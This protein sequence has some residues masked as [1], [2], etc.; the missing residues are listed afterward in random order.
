MM[1]EEDN[2]KEEIDKE[3]EK[4]EVNEEEIKE[5]REGDEKKEVN[6][7]EGKEEKEETN[8]R[9][10]GEVVKEDEKQGE[11]S[12][13]DEKKEEDNEKEEIDKVEEKD[14]T[15]E[16]KTTEPN[17]IDKEQDKGEAKQLKKIFLVLGFLALIFVGVF[18]F[19]NSSRNFTYD[20]IDFETVKAG[21]L[22]LYKT[23]LPVDSDDHKITGD[24]VSVNY[25]F[26]LR[27]DPRKLRNIPVELDDDFSVLANTVINFTESFNC[28][29]MGVVAVTNMANLLEVLDVEVMKDE[30]A[31][32][33]PE[34]RYTFLRLQRGNETSIEQ[35]GPSCYNLNVNNCEI[36]EVTEKYMLELLSIINERLP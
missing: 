6:G 1:D 32:C 5:G 16:E 12:K 31:V 28:D 13:G 25:N 23:S 17:K 21:E 11:E 7:E 20:G 33:D 8:D 9:E 22:I 2:E 24:A 4:K 15:K 34:K 14:V 19:M 18:I 35:F 36:L 30:T 26:F 29:G 27:N 10:K 3:E